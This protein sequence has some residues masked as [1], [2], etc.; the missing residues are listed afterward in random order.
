MSYEEEFKTM[1]IRV[2][3]TMK[4]QFDSP[5]EFWKAVGLMFA[6]MAGQ[7]TRIQLDEIK[8]EFP[9]PYQ[10]VEECL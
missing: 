1:A 5:K 10:F 2:P 4:E 7:F 9:I 8:A 3:V 6:A